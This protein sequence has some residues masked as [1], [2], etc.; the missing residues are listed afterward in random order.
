[1]IGTTPKTQATR[2]RDSARK[3]RGM[4]SRIK[5]HTRDKSVKKR[6]RKTKRCRHAYNSVV[7][8][9]ENHT[10]V[11]SGA[12]QKAGG[13]S[14]QQPQVSKQRGATSSQPRR[15]AMEQS[16][17]PKSWHTGTYGPM[18]E[19]LPQVASGLEAAILSS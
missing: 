6:Q 17:T 1:M 13:L 7:Q 4:C 3:I 5:L 10:T 8:G 2:P 9:M 12:V 11:A 18:S 19:T 16:R 14:T 15:L